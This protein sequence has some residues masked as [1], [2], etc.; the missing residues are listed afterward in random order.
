MKLRTLVF[1]LAVMLVSCGNVDCRGTPGPGPFDPSPAPTHGTP[2]AG[3]AVPVTIQ[4]SDYED[5][6]TEARRTGKRVLIY[7]DAVWCGYCREIDAHVWTDPE[8]RES[9]IENYVAARVD[10]DRNPEIQEQFGVVGVPR[11]LIYDV[12]DNEVDLRIKGWYED[13]EIYRDALD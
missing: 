10:I 5:A 13:I 3:P 4:W 11:I 12:E 2:D 8:V 1:T 7:F 9:V 6:V